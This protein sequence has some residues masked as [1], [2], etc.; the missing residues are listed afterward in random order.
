MLR[1]NRLS[2]IASLSRRIISQFISGTTISSVQTHISAAATF[3]FY[4]VCFFGRKKKHV[5][6][7]DTVKTQRNMY[8]SATI[9]GNDA[10]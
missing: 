4:R 7:D 2:S 1:C 9:I 5:C 3:R 8:R 10:Y 6:F